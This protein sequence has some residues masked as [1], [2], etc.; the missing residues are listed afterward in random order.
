MSQNNNRGA[1]GVASQSLS[2][3]NES[4]ARANGVETETDA[5]A[6]AD[7]DAEQ[8]CPNCG[9]SASSNGA[10]VAFLDIRSASKACS[11]ETGCV[12]DG[13]RIQLEYC[14]SNGLLLNAAGYVLCFCPIARKFNLD[15]FAPCSSLLTVLSKTV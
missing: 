7:V 8:V 10:I 11:A 13:V 9:M 5:D 15:A 1:N 3:A 6:D 12:V 14:E 4:L 2:V